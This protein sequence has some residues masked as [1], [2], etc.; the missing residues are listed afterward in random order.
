MSE[1]NKSIAIRWMEDNWN[2]RR[3][4]VV[5]ELMDIECCG[6]MEGPGCEG[7]QIKTRDEWR[8]ARDQLIA[9]FPDL[10]VDVEQAVAE[11]DTVVLRWKASGTH[12][13]DALGL[14]A[15]QRAMDVVGS[16]WMTIRNGK[17]VSG[18]D[19][20]NQGDLMARLAAA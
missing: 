12:K 2:R 11:G 5:D 19:T 9:A 15:T 10:R 16:T 6:R 13:G 20:W 3:F 14:R 17:I 7:M 8:A 4:E 1:A 18:F